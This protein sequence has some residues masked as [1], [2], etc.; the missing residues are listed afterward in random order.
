MMGNLPKEYSEVVTK[1]S[2]TLNPLTLNPVEKEI[3]AHWKYKFN[4]G[5]STKSSMP[6]A[7]VVGSFGRGKPKGGD[8]KRHKKP[9]KKPFKGRCRKCGKHGHK[10]SSYERCLF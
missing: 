3:K 2:G 8:D 9:F 6:L 4:G 7:M 5:K 1:M 10:A